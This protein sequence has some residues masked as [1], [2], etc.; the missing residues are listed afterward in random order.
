MGCII[1]LHVCFLSI[2]LMD[3]LGFMRS[4]FRTQ[5]LGPEISSA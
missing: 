1:A 4:E 3:R 5:G 2:S